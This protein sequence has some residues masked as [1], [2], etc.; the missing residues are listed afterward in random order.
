MA[1]QEEAN[2]G[3]LR[4]AMEREH[5][6]QVDQLQVGSISSEVPTVQSVVHGQV[7]AYQQLQVVLACLPGGQGGV[8]LIFGKGKRKNSGTSAHDICRAALCVLSPELGHLPAKMM[9]AALIH[10]FES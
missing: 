4:A 5:A 2:R 8:S 3:E 6:E 7:S 1:T 10:Q 9:E